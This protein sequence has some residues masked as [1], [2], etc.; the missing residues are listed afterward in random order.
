MNIYI[1]FSKDRQNVGMFSNGKLFECSLE[2]IPTFAENTQLVFD[3]QNIE[4]KEM[5]K[6]FDYLQPLNFL[7]IRAEIVRVAT[8][9]RNNKLS[10]K[11][12]TLTPSVKALIETNS[13]YKGLLLENSCKLNALTTSFYHSELIAQINN[14]SNR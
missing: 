13:D 11:E 9:T 2:T 10:V 6:K 12:N 1:Y 4:Y 7:D 5:V 14:K 8:L 3:S